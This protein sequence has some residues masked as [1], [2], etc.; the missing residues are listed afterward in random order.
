MPVA[1]DALERVAA[2]LVGFES[3]SLS[4][5]EASAKRDEDSEG[6]PRIR[7]VAIV[8]PPAGGNGWDVDE[9]LTLQSRAETLLHEEDPD[10]P[11]VLVELRTAEKEPAGDEAEDDV[12]SAFRDADDE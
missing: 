5:S 11:W 3:G 7:V 4:V 8:N 2:A 10:A 6:N 12:E 1:N 9:V